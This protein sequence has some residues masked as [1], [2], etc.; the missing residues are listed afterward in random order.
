MV[1]PSTPEAGDPKSPLGFLDLPP[2]IRLEIYPHLLSASHLWR[3]SH[4]I[5][6]PGQPPRYTLRIDYPGLLPSS[7]KL[8]YQPQRSYGCTDEPFNPQIL[9][10]CSQIRSEASTF[11]YSTHTFS[12]LNDPTSSDIDVHAQLSYRATARACQQLITRYPTDDWEITAPNILQRS[13]LA[14]FLRK[15][16]P[17]NAA[18][19]QNLELRSGPTRV[20]ADDM[21]LVAELC[22]AHL[23]VEK[24]Q[25]RWSAAVRRNYHCSKCRPLWAK[26]R[27]G[28]VYKALWGFVRKVEWLKGLQYRYLG[29]WD[30]EEWDTRGKIWEPQEAAE[31]RAREARWREVGGLQRKDIDE[32]AMDYSERWTVNATVAVAVPPPTPP[33][34]PP[35]PTKA[36]MLEW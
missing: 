20:A 36:D 21:T 29:P 13:P 11:L 3:S 23:Q 17:A 5:F 24:T 1:T 33:P 12:I 2:E 22:A 25:G 9:A 35:P 7:A 19:V 26:G 28:S 15:I 6:N 14:A 4:P 8:H 10:T 34:P 31:E 32:Q 30:T 27:F 18:L 16:G